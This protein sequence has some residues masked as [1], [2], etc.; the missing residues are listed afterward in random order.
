MQEAAET[1]TIVSSRAGGLDAE[2]QMNM[3]KLNYDKMGHQHLN[4]LHPHV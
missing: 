1:E 4:K 3:E 2:G